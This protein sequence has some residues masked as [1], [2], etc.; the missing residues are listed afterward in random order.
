[1]IS[2][3]KRWKQKIG[4]SLFFPSKSFDDFSLLTKLAE[5]KGPF[6]VQNS[7]INDRSAN[8]FGIFHVPKKDICFPRKTS[9][10]LLESESDKTGKRAITARDS[11]N[12][13]K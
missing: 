3:I 2:T 10:I 11:A 1:M 6:N 7:D 4:P 5:N 12:R 8:T 13:Q 9:G